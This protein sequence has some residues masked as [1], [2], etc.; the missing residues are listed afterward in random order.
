MRI[1]EKSV[2]SNVNKMT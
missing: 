2:V 1:D